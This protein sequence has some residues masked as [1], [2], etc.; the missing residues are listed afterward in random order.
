MKETQNNWDLTS[1]SFYDHENDH[2]DLINDLKAAGTIVT[3]KTIGNTLRRERL[4]SCSARTESTCTARLKFDNDSEENWVKVLW[5]DE[6]KIKLFDIN[7]T[8]RVWRRKTRTPSPPSN[9]E[10]ETLC[11]G[12][13]F[14]LRGQDNCTAS[15]G[16][17]TWPCTVRALKM[18]H[19]WVF[20]HDNEPRQQ[21]R[22][23]K[24]S[25]LRSWSGLASLQTIIPKKIC[26]GSWRFE[27]PKRQPRNLNDFERIY[28]EEWVKIPP[29]MCTNLVTDYKKL[30]FCC[31]Y[32]VS[33]CSNKPTITIIDWS[34]ICRWANIHNQQGIFFFPHYIYFIF[35]FSVVIFHLQY[36]L[37]CSVLFFF[38]I[39]NKQTIYSILLLYFQ[40]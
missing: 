12:G 16:R 35:I 21:R 30:Y 34:F 17:W 5:S 22:G 10:V 31:C 11:F 9:M 37:I 13:V 40:F 4:K 2:A 14:L 7:S 24:R 3:K 28:K 18:G 27:L 29:E 32:S 36:I 8:R 25:T 1:W 33:H 20:Q 26:A 38:V 6:A 23:S 15:K 39:K 19:G